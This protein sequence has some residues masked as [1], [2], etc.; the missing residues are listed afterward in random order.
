MVIAFFAAVFAVYIVYLQLKG[1]SIAPTPTKPTTTYT[2]DTTYALLKPATVPPKISECSQTLSYDSN[3]NP[4]PLQCADG[5]LNVLAWNALAA[6]EPKVMTLGYQPT[7]AQVKAAI[8]TDGN[9]AN[10]DSSSII[11]APLETSAY[12]LA[13]LYYGWHFSISP[14]AL[15]TNG[16]C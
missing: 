14:E 16:G 13:S 11:S 10:A 5:S 7:V 4:S 2:R 3:G 6:L 15:L 9:D 12:Q 8:C 1:N